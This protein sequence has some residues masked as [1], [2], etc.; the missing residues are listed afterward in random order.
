MIKKSWVLLSFQLD[1]TS[2]E[3]IV[4]KV[5]FSTLVDKRHLQT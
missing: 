2:T 3:N 1:S 4:D 5:L